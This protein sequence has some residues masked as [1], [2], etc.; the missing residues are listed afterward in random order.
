MGSHWVVLATV[1]VIA[2]NSLIIDKARKLTDFILRRKTCFDILMT[3]EGPAVY[4]CRMRCGKEKYHMEN[5][6]FCVRPLT[7]VRKMKI[8]K[9]YIC[10]VGF[11]KKRRCVTTPRFVKCWLPEAYYE[12]NRNDIEESGES[13]NTETNT[14]TEIKGQKLPE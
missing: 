4:K 7:R 13:N 12:R 11:C 6:V 14:T 5:A 1:L 8:D 3:E 9:K 10:L 2:A